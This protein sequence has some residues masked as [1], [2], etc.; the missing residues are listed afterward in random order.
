MHWYTGEKDA[1]FFLKNKH[2]LVDPITCHTPQ[3]FP[4]SIWFTWSNFQVE[5]DRI[6]KRLDR[7][8]LTKHYGF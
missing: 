4:N 3:S 6:I 5:G 2:G 7:A 1:R 8:I